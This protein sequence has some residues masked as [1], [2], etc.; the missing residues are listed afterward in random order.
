MYYSRIF[1]FNKIINHSNF[2]IIIININLKI[3]FKF[4][5]KKLIKQN[6]F[7]IFT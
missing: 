6:Y 3:I 5:K 2:I 1:Y 7:Y 4:L